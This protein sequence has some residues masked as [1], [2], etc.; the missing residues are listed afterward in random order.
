AYRTR[1]F[2]HEIIARDLF[3]KFAARLFDELDHDARRLL[4][5]WLGE[6]VEFSDSHAFMERLG[7]SDIRTV[8]NVKRRIRF[9]ARSILD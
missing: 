7:I 5:A 4:D 9:K 3:Q 8:H 1:S 2:L 6:G